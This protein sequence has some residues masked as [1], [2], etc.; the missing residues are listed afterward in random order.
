MSLRAG[1]VGCG[2]ITDT[3]VRAAREAGWTVGGF[4][5][6]RPEKAE[7]FAARHGGRAFRS[8]EQLLDAPLEVV[9][10]GSPSG[11][12]AE[13]GMAAA[14]RGRHVLV[15]KPIDVAVERA[16]ALV[17]AAERAGVRIGVL[18]QDRLNP[19]L[20]RLREA[21]AQGALGR[22]LLVSA[23]V[24][25]HRPPEYYAG[26]RW[27]GTKALDGGAALVNQGIHTVDL[28]LWLLGPVARV[29]GLVATALHAIEGEDTALALLEFASGAIGTLE[30]TTVAW[31]GYPR[32]VEIT[33]TGGT[34]MVEGDAVVAADLRH[35]LPGLVTAAAGG[36]SRED[37][38]T[39]VVSDATP[40]R[41][42]FEDFARAIA[43][44][45]RPAC[46]GGEAL[47]SLALVRA[48]Y[49]AAARPGLEVA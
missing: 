17:E 11:L 7:A 13:H 38:K 19:E 21:I 9:V 6:S 37:A 25:W 36:T 44:G 31:P 3:H 22:V 24:K 8:L 15:E 18:Y 39:P 46:D 16:R 48:V 27:R 45:G 47:R 29:R 35:P 34:V 12:H 4:V 41:R 33:G 49:A 32:R 20:V 43:G 28:L 5:G 14:G 23:R 30:A 1:F 2:N 42:L 26:S 10:I 40:H